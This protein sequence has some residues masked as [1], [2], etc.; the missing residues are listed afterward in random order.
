MKLTPGHRLALDVLA[1]QAEL[2]AAHPDDIRGP[3]PGAVILGGLTRRQRDHDHDP[4]LSGPGQV[5]PAAFRALAE[6]D[7]AEL[8]DHGHAVITSEGRLLAAVQ[9]FRR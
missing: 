1:H 3:A 9:R 5:H 4:A 7:L 2:D 8:L 6:A